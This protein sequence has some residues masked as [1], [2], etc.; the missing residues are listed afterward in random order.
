MMPLQESLGIRR[1]VQRHQHFFILGAAQNDAPIGQF[2]DFEEG[3]GHGA[4]LLAGRQCNS[5]RPQALA[6]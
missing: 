3:S 4:V 5:T 1:E 2:D 6:R